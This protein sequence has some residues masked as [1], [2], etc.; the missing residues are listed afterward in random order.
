MISCSCFLFHKSEEVYDVVRKLLF[1]RLTPLLLLKSLPA[2]ALVVEDYTNTMSNIGSSFSSSNHNFTTTTTATS[3]PAS[4]NVDTLARQDALDT[5]ATQRAEAPISE[6]INTLSCRD[7]NTQACQDTRTLACRDTSTPRPDDGEGED[8][9]GEESI[10]SVL[11][12]VS[13][14]LWERCSRVYEYDQVLWM[15]LWSWVYLLN[16]SRCNRNIYE[17]SQEFFQV[18]QSLVTIGVGGCYGSFF[19]RNSTSNNRR[20]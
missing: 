19:L 13:G 20:K 14:L 11:D 8:Q 16:S 4:G 1:A 18:H 6:D 7:T 10:G 15:V 9:D 12:E 5:V 2:T 3:I 17:K